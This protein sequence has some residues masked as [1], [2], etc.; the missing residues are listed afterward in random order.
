MSGDGAFGFIDP[1][2]VLRGCHI[3]P[4]FAKGK[5]QADGVGISHCAKDVRDYNQYYVGSKFNYF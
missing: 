2:D 5:Q 1:K 4:N 3:I